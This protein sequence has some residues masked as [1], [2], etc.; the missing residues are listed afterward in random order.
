MESE[1]NVI[2]LA[3]EDYGFE[4]ARVELG[5]KHKAAIVACLGAL[6]CTVV[7]AGIHLTAGRA[8][9]IMEKKRE[10]ISALLAYLRLHHQSDEWVIMGDT[11]WPDSEQCPLEEEFIDVS[12]MAGLETYEPTANSLAAATARESRE[13]Q[14]YDRIFIKRGSKLSIIPESTQLFGLPHTGGAPASD[15]WGL[16]SAVNLDST[17]KPLTTITPVISVSVPLLSLLPT[18][19]T[20][21]ELHNFCAQFDYVPSDAQNAMFKRAVDTLDTFL[22]NLSSPLVVDSDLNSHTSAVRL[23]ASPV[24]SYALGC[25]HPASDV[26][27]VVVGNI[28]PRT[29]WK[30]M[31]RKIRSSVGD[32]SSIRLR[33]FVGDA[34][35]QIMEL[36]VHGMKMDIQYCPAGRLIDW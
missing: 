22:F 32:V 4:W 27:C 24:G 29:F 23:V 3:R 8:P 20:D 35:V 2:I 1:R 31:R 9:P 17:F 34:S 28:N 36:E 26:D 25:H 5:G 7:I 14:R 19:I 12:F 11:N 30:L 13:P 21:A 33:R 6:Q 10:E 18:T 15:H 16:K